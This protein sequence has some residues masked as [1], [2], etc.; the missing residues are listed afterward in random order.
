M[1]SE[2]PKCGVTWE[3][4]EIPDG[5]MQHAPRRYTSRAKAEEAARSYGWTPENKRKFKINM[6][7]IEYPWNHPRHYDGVSEWKCTQCGT[8]IDRFTNKIIPEEEREED[9]CAL[10]GSNH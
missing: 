3:G 9:D 4:E 8:R 10:R 5:L 7:G 2:C 1:L 6:V